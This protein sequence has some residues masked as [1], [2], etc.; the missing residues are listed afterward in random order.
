MFPVNEWNHPFMQ[1][2]SVFLVRPLHS[3][4]CIV[5][6]F[7]THTLNLHSRVRVKP[8]SVLHTWCHLSKNFMKVR[9]SPLVHNIFYFKGKLQ[10]LLRRGENN[11][12][13]LTLVTLQPLFIHIVLKW[14]ES[15]VNGYYFH[16]F[17]ASATPKHALCKLLLP[18]IF[19]ILA[20]RESYTYCVAYT[21]ILEEE[22]HGN[23]YP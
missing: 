18:T 17:I 20:G 23:H 8:T 9:L 11:F 14:M 21:R 16:A 12:V 4:A 1:T 22:L 10:Q 19:I 13:Q 15:S 2:Y 5:P 3:N 6:I 7:I